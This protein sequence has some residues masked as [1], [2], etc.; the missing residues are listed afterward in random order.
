M[1]YV[2]HQKTEPQFQPLPKNQTSSHSVKQL[3]K[4]AQGAKEPLE[5]PATAGN[6][7]RFKLS[8]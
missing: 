7:L 2:A 4:R 8:L 6:T 5:T 1:E 3:P